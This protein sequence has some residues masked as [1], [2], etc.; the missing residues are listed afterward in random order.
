MSPDELTN[1]E[2]VKEYFESLPE[3]KRDNWFYKRAVALCSGKSDPMEP[4]K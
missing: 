4:L 3:E 2:K 1:W